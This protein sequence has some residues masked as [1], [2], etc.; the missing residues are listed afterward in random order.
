VA[1]CPAGQALSWAFHLIMQH[2][3]VEEKL[4]EEAERVLGKPTVS[5]ATPASSCAASGAGAA[6][7]ATAPADGGDSGAASPTSSSVASD[8]ALLLV[9]S[10]RHTGKTTGDAA[11]GAGSWVQPSYDQLRKLS[12]AKAVFL[13]ALRLF[14]SVPQVRGGGCGCGRAADAPVHQPM[15]RQMHHCPACLHR[16]ICR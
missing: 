2:P 5:A 3:E 15:Q 6:S 9:G 1:V 13:E 12:Y 4:L 7:I 11:G 14:P 8:D 16:H 10:P